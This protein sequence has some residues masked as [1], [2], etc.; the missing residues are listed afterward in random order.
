MPSLSIA[1]T[2]VVLKSFL[3]VAEC[4]LCCM[5]CST[6]RQ[7][8]WCLNWLRLV[9]DLFRENFLFIVYIEYSNYWIEFQLKKYFSTNTH[10]SF[11]FFKKFYGISGLIEK[12]ITNLWIVILL[13]I[14]AIQVL[15]HQSEPIGFFSTVTDHR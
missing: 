8:V 10:Y 5:Y 12:C 3:S 14:T 6:K 15:P 1:R 11:Y 2:F 9:C 4:Q 7:S 13:Y